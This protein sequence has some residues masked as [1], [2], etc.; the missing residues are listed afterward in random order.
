MCYNIIL[1]RGRFTFAKVKFGSMSIHKKKGGCIN[2]LNLLIA[3]VKKLRFIN[4]RL[5]SIIGS[6]HGL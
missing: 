1:F 4:D 5:I 2:G 3:G 6:S